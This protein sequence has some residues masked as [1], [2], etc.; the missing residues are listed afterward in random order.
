MEDFKGK[1]V[2]VTGAAT[3]MGRDA[4]LAFGREGAK[5]VAVTG[6]NAAA[7]EET[8][9]AIRNAGGEAIFIQCDVSD[10]EQVKAM[11][12][13]TLSVYGRLDCAFNNAGIGPDGVRVPFTA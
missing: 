11:V 4:A 3:G 9:Q 13:K 10:E 12:E 6:H 5:V 2:I 8:A 7:G 1:V